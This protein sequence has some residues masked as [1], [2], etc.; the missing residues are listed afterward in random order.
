MTLTLRAVSL[1]DQPLTQPITAQFG[2]EGG[3][4]GRADQNTLALPD[5]ERHIS[6]H[7]AEISVHGDSYAIKNIGSANPIIVHGQP[8]AQGVSAALTHH[9]QVRIGGYLLEVIDDGLLGTDTT[10]VTRP[11]TAPAEPKTPMRTAAALAAA[12]LAAPPQVAPLSSSNPFAD[13]LGP[14]PAAAPMQAGAVPA[15]A[16]TDDPFADLP[17]PAGLSGASA[18]WA[19]AA[20]AAPRLPDDFDP[21]AASAPAAASPLSA[22]APGGAGA[23]DDLIPSA[24]A[25]SIDE[26]FGLQQ[27]GSSQDPLAAFMAGA[28]AQAAGSEPRAASGLSTDPLALFGG[29]K[30]EAPGMP[31]TPDDASELRGAFK[32]PGL[33]DTPDPLLP[34]G[35]DW[36]AQ[37]PK[38]PAATVPPMPPTAARSNE[39]QRPA[40][41][42][43]PPE[44]PE[45]PEAAAV[46]AAANKAAASAEAG[47]W[48]G[49][50]Q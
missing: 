38:R 17:P 45:A 41:A 21:F 16:K 37:S 44:A 10:T 20:P 11:R 39:A 48:A 7:Q 27:S 30:A 32:P 25:P 8:L 33:R 3:T 6:R 49:D 26:A 14:A 46:H 36:L 40:H 23:F 15:A 28:P 2:A 42:V 1:N 5:P 12:Q 34:S 9:D 50:T 4:I 18:A 47:A 13:L 29:T 43:T 35:L 19:A 24:A 31:T 22:P